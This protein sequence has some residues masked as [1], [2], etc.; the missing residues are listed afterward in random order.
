[1]RKRIALGLMYCAMAATGAS[2]GSLAAR[3]QGKLPRNTA[4]TLDHGWEFRQV[5]AGTLGAEGGWL[6]ATVPGDVHLDLLAN[7]KIPDSF[8]RDNEA[9]APVDRR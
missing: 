4:V 8:F 6:P 2:L 5:E 1:M 7:K 9:R 3:A